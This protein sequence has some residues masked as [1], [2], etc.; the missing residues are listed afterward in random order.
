MPLSH[1]TFGRLLINPNKFF[2]STYG[3]GIRKLI[4][5]EKSI[6]KIVDFGDAQVFETAT[7]YTCLIFL[8]KKSNEMLQ[9]VPIFNE[10]DFILLDS[11]QLSFQT[12]KI[13]KGN[14]DWA[15]SATNE[16]SIWEKFSKLETLIDYCDEIFQGLISGG[17]KLFFLEFI[18]E[19][20]KFIRAKS[21]ITNTVFDIE[22]ELCFKL[23]KGSEIKRY[24]QP[25][26]KFVALFP[27]F[28]NDF[29]RTAL[30]PEITL[31]TKYPKT[32]HYL[33][34]F[35]RE[36]ST[37][38]SERMEYESWYA[39]WCPRTLEK[40]TANKIITQVLASSAN[41]TVDYTGKTL[42]VGGGN[43]GGYGIIPK[44]ENNLLYLLGLLNSNLMDFYLHKHSSKFRG[45]FFSYARRFIQNCPIP[46]ATKAQQTKIAEIADE[47]IEAKKQNPK[48]E[49]SKLEGKVDE[50]VYQLYGL[51]D[52]EIRIVEG[53]E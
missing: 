3:V 19:N 14:D 23:L 52:E 29:Q 18:A 12:H 9:Y 35:R 36:L 11:G 17:D 33:S 25:Q 39:M 51:T 31:K 47:I 43:A 24:S 6:W 45:G 16:A 49:T 28:L 21:T 37:R 15:F 10:N 7:T 13:P 5:N 1:K 26:N 22:K 32:Y 2:N 42:F 40:F 46:K 34:T 44:D 20:D 50:L 41:Y 8:S 38:G 27:Y 48:A 53:K 30:I 4:A